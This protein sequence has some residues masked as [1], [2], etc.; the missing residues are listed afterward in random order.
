MADTCQASIFWYT[1][2]KFRQYNK[3]SPGELVPL[4]II[5]KHQQGLTLGFSLKWTCSTCLRYRLILTRVRQNAEVA[6][7]ALLYR[8]NFMRV[9]DTV[10]DINLDAGFSVMRLI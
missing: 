2:K 4:E 9:Y 10:R 3:A 1:L 5:G 8:W 6:R 7:F